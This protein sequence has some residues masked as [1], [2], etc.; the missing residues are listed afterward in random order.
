MTRR[1]APRRRMR[2]TAARTLHGLVAGMV[3]AGVVAFV[4]HRLAATP[5]AVR[6]GSGAVDPGGSVDAGAR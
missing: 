6:D 2:S 5:R 4:E 3:L 1:A